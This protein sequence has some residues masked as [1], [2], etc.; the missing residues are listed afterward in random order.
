MV[1]AIDFIARIAEKSEGDDAR[2]YLGSLW[3]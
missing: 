1:E 2:W 3:I